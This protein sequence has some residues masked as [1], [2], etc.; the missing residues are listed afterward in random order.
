M[1]SKIILL[2]VLLIPSICFGLSTRFKISH[3]EINELL[4][5]EVIS[6]MEFDG[7]PYAYTFVFKTTTSQFQ[8]KFA[9]EQRQ[10]NINALEHCL[11]THFPK[12]SSWITKKEYLDLSPELFFEKMKFRAVQNGFSIT[13]EKVSNPNS[14]EK[15]YELDINK[16]DK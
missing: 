4:S 2:L 6:S 5:F 7:E 1:K 15:L 3:F 14:L 16:P 10:S 9:K 8:T 11:I 13:K 12:H